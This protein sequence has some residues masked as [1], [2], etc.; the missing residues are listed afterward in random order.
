MTQ[1]LPSSRTHRYADDYTLTDSCDSVSTVQ[2]CMDLG[3]TKCDDTSS[4]RCSC[5]ITTYHENDM[6]GSAANVCTS[7]DA[8]SYG[9]EPGLVGRCKMC[10][11]G[12]HTALVGQALCLPCLPGKFGNK[13]G[14]AECHECDHGKMNAVPNATACVD[15]QM[16]YYQ[17]STSQAS[18][19]PCLPGKFGDETGLHSATSAP[20]QDEC[21]AKRNSVCGLQRQAASPTR[22]GVTC[23]K[24]RTGRYGTPMPQNMPHL[25]T[26]MDPGRRGSVW[27]HYASTWF[28]C[29]GRSS[30]VNI[31]RGWTAVDCNRDDVSASAL[32]PV[33]LV[34]TTTVSDLAFCVRQAGQV[35]KDKRHAIRAIRGST[36]RI[37]R[38]AFALTVLLDG[39]RIKTSRQV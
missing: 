7:C 6:R 36:V 12:Y 34:R 10:P 31:S 13:T 32:D 8:G 1:V 28:H 20:R 9:D 26:R 23:T 25:S 38:Q 33:L 22:K 14:L 24:C 17:A 3:F 35:S 15:C 37:S 19:L 27:L 39:S 18:C 30:F 11:A 5:P 4:T 2:L 16:G 29:C 21:G